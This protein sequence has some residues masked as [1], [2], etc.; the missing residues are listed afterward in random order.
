L[1]DKTSSGQ[2]LK[3][4]FLIKKYSM[5]FESRQCHGQ[6]WPLSANFVT[7]GQVFDVQIT[8]IDEWDKL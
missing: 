3:M 7:G 1:F 2:H 6:N 5:R 4:Q 8:N